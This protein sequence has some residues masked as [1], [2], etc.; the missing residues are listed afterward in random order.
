MSAP[1]TANPLT[2]PELAAFI[3][4]VEAG[5]VQGAADA[6]GLTQS[7]VTK[8]LQALEARVGVRL[9]ERGHFGV[10]PTAAGKV[11]YPDAKR[12]VGALA[13]AH[14]TLA[15]HV[16]A[17]A[18]VLRLSA[19]HTVG[20]VLLPD[21]LAAFRR[22]AAGVR[23]QLEVTN[24]PAVLRA[25]RAGDADIGFVEGPDPLD[26][27]EA[28]TI[29]HDELV[30]VVADGHPWARRPAVAPEALLAE[31]Y[32][33]RE[34]GSGT[35]AIAAAALAAACVELHPNLELAS[36]QSVKRAL[37]GGGFALMSRLVVDAEVSAGTLRTL[38]IDG[39]DLARRLVAV[40]DPQAPPRPAAS[41]F[42]SWLAQA[43]PDR[44]AAPGDAVRTA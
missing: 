40:R 19:S 41:A 37:R 35:R 33:A 7:A 23:A 10:R 17:S 15:A 16:D 42:W 36:S 5:S 3:A 38:S 6:L 9:L 13:A 43:A 26:G 2:G 22:S 18:V 28:L 31:T 24:S 14:E 1:S 34:C 32:L 21:R 4:A 8:R 44:A 20:E 25:V 39:I 27:L 30:V 11:L 12:A 29:A